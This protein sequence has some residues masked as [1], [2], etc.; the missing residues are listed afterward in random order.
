[1]PKQ[2]SSNRSTQIDNRLALW[3]DGALPPER[4]KNK[5][6]GRL[7]PHIKGLGDRSKD[8]VS[9]V[10]PTNERFISNDALM[11]I[12]GIK[13]L[14]SSSGL[15]IAQKTDDAN[16]TYRR[17]N[18]IMQPE[19][20]LLEP[21]TIYDS[22]PYVRQAINRKISL[23]F[24]NGFE[25]TGDQDPDIDYIQRRFEAM[26]YVM[27]R[28][29]GA[30]FTQILF[31]LLLCSN[32]FLQKIR[33][34]SATIVSRK[35]EASK[36]PVAGYLLIPAHMIFPY[37]ENGIPVKWRRFFDTGAPFED[38]D[39]DDVIHMKWDV[40]PGHRYGT[41]RV[42][43][44][45]EDIFALRRLEENVEL[46]FINFLFPLFHVAVGNEENPAAF[47]GVSGA[48]EVDMISQQIQNMPKEGVFVTDERVTVSAVGSEG[49]ALD[50]S[51]LI[52]HYKARIFTGLGMSAADM[53]D[54][55]SAG[56]R[57]TA[58]N[59]SQNL[60][61][62]IKSDLDLFGGMIQL[63]MFK[64]FFREA[65]YS[66]SVQKATTRTW[67]HFH[68]I[69]MDN[70][71]K[72]ENHVVQLFLNNL[73][74]EDEARKAI[75]AR[76]FKPAQHKNLNF[77]LYT[78]RLVKETQ[79]AQT[80]GTIEIA[81]HAT[82]QQEKLLPLQTE[83]VQKQANIE[84]KKSAQLTEHHERKS[85]A[86][87]ALLGKKIEHAKAVGAPQRATSKKSNPARKSVQNKETPTN[88]YGSN[89]GPTK[90]KSGLE[91]LAAECTDELV[92]LIEDLKDDNGTVNHEAYRDGI[93]PL[94]EGIITG[95]EQ[96]T[97]EL[98]G[99]SYT[100]QA[101]MVV[102]Q[103]TPILMTTYDPEMISIIVSEAFDISDKG[104]DQD[105]ESESATQ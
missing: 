89:L 3:S 101:R 105:G 43:G 36:D 103:L 8:F 55:K 35:D 29:T 47:D 24:R 85:T 16:P 26:E 27:E 87:I 86:S 11:T 94:L 20:N 44:V 32:C 40:K 72:Y 34:E 30:F 104:E 73:I 61:D 17:L 67:I 57:S 14:E 102:D 15:S 83:H 13:K 53:G 23:M 54:S 59:I 4:R 1:M 99:N 75:G 28:T 78:L 39:L 49:K 33:K 45:K 51:K 77:E 41:P 42:V 95:I 98:E 48:S 63:S 74:D 90:A 10:K 97:G 31:N 38:I 71:I 84:T 9:K 60:K 88:Q 56:S 69:D 68:E 37:M 82:E 81:D 92:Q 80:E 64:E 79:K 12:D 66:V 2:I 65:T 91:S 7:E 76:A 58:D 21:F 46:L 5:S 52:E 62:A 50:Y 100:R 93:R 70:K 19:Y 18:G 25:F 96:Q 6:S 22:E